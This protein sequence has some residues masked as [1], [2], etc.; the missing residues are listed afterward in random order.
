MSTSPS[1]TSDVSG[2]ATQ[3]VANGVNFDYEATPILRDVS[4]T[5]SD[6]DV[7]GLVGDN[8]AG[9]STLLWVLSGRRKPTSGTVTHVGTRVIGSQELEAP[10]DSTV[11]MLIDEAL[12]PSKRRLADL[13]E[14]AEALSTA[15]TPEASAAA[16]K[17]YSKIFSDVMAHDDWNAEHNAEIVLDH[18]GLTGTAPDGA[19]LT[20]QLTTEISGGQRAR[21]GLAIT[22]IRKPEILLLDEPTNHLDERGRQLVID[23]IVNHPGVVVVATHDRDFLDAVCTVIGDLV[24]GRPGIGLFRGN[25][26]DYAKHRRHERDLWEHQWRTEE[27]ERNRLE[28]TIETG[29]R[30]VSPGRDMTDNNKMAYDRR[31]GRVERQ[32]AR[33]VRSAKQR[34]EEL[35]EE[36]VEKPPALLGF[37]APLTAPLP[38]KRA[39]SGS[40]EDFHIKMRGVVVPDRIRVGSLTI[41]PGDKVVITGPNGAGKS[42]LFKT[43]MGQIEPQAGEVRVNEDARI[44]MLAQEQNWAN[45]KK[46]ARQLYDMAPNPRVPLDDLGLL[47]PEDANRPVGDLSVGQQRRVAL[48]LVVA[49]PPE[50]LLLDEPTNHLS[51]DL[52]EQVQDAI[53][54]AE[55]TILVITHDHR[56]VNS[57]E[58]RHLQVNEG[59]VIELPKGQKPVEFV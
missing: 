24:P 35:Q 40:D 28:D 23:T 58:A 18:L 16:E 49:N 26:S 3:L 33:R 48:A 51:V 46:S 54:A 55:G 17:E 50:I 8:G 56:M 52:I 36:G 59:E 34:L 43:I 6:G 47:S 10:Y 7:L 53:A 22:L 20:E 1:P 37:D 38:T 12:G 44:A 57:L 15:D 25:Y 4:L 41:R 27:H 30:Q 11:Q 39:A 29:A 42:T 31:G 5:L 45:P 2:K 19:P 13:E 9:K 32:I 21:L 14:A